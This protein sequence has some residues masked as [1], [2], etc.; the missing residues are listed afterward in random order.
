MSL[1]SWVEWYNELNG[2]NW[3]RLAPDGMEVFGATAA[4][5]DD[6]EQAT[7]ARRE[8]KLQ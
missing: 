2:R 3:D 5:D 6:V 8:G 1:R 4:S 7:E